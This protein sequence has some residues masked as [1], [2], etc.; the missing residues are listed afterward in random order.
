MYLLKVGDFFSLKYL[1]PFLL[2]VDFRSQ[3]CCNEVFFPSCA[4]SH[5]RRCPIATHIERPFICLFRC[6]Q[7]S[8]L[9]LPGPHDASPMSRCEQ[10]ISSKGIWESFVL[11]F[12]PKLTV[13]WFLGKPLSNVYHH[14]IKVDYMILLQ[15]N[16]PRT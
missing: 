8:V 2:F 14:Q 12:G 5:C 4:V 10:C 1:S 13:S 16:Y 3:V 7:R 11:G 6:L 9:Y 15:K